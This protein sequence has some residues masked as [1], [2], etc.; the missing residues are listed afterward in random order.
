MGFEPDNQQ[1]LGGS[2]TRGVWGG[3][4]EGEASR[5]SGGEIASEERFARE[6]VTG[7]QGDFPPA[8]ATGPDPAGIGLGVQGG[9][10]GDR[11][12]RVEGLGDGE[13][14]EVEGA[15]R[16][17][18]EPGGGVKVVEDGQVRFRAARASL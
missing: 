6:H 11:G 17:R 9:G 4:G 10:G 7:E 12:E 16:Q 18:G 8:N 13:G 14:A 1:H 2:G 5:E 3:I 15:L